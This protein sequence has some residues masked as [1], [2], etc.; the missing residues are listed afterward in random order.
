MFI[1]KLDTSKSP[2]SPV[3]VWT[4]TRCLQ[5]VQSNSPK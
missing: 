3:I 2:V 4:I 1:S 5:S